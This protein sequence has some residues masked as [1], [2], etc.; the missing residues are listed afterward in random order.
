MNNLIVIGG[1]GVES[2]KSTVANI[3][4]YQ[5]WIDLKQRKGYD[6][7]DKLFNYKQ[8]CRL[9]ELQSVPNDYQIKKFAD[10]LKDIVCLMIGKDRH[11]LEENKNTKLGD[12]WKTDKIKYT[13]RL[14]MKHIGTTLFRDQLIPDIH[15]NMLFNE[16]NENSNWIIDDL[17]FRNEYD[18][19]K[20]YNGVTIYVKRGEDEIDHVEGQ[21]LESDFDYVIDNNGD[22]S[23][24]IS[25]VKKV[26]NEIQSN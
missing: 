20:K 16:Y 4:L 19:V 26:Y 1:N 7:T 6:V 17:R 18:R 11:W 13:P 2:G 9:Q 22:I 12:D 8:F 10:K 25:K 3:L 24:L 5:I 14:L 15:V 23:D 21:L